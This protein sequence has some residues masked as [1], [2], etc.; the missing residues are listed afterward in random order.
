MAPKP[1]NEHLPIAIIGAGI[2]GLTLAQ[3]CRRHN[4][5][6]RLLERHPH[7]H[8]RQGHRFRVSE[9][10]FAALR[11][12]ALADD[13]ELRDLLV[14]TAPCRRKEGVAQR[15][16]R[17][18]DAKTF[19]MDERLLARTT[20]HVHSVPIDRG[21]V[22]AVLEEGLGDAVEYGREFLR[23]EEKEDEGED[24]R[25]FVRVWFT[26]GSFLDASLLV[27]A[28]GVRSLVRRQLQPARRLLDLNR[29]I[30][31]GRTP[32]VAGAHK[33]GGDNDT[34]MSS[35][36][37]AVDKEAGAQCVVEAITWD[38]EARQAAADAGLSPS[39]LGDYSYW[40]IATAPASGEHGLPQTAEETRAFVARITEGWHPRLKKVLDGADYGV[41]TCIP[42]VSSK[43]DIELPVEGNGERR[44]GRVLVTII[45]DAAHAMSPMGQAGGDLAIRDAV[46]L[47][48]AI[49]R[50]RDEEE[51]EEQGRSLMA[52]ERVM[53]ARAKENLERAFSNGR[54]FWAKEGYREV[55]L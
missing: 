53:A 45:G 20:A 54:R 18:P 44:R 33:S 5:P 13:R 1:P 36:L 46:D 17:F 49:A 16:P 47:A 34:D 38:D 27:G 15:P 35:W 40:A 41:A 10:A 11:D 2:A 24:G 23:Y 26:D 55:H 21:W 51:G 4:I 7:G 12:D 30:V 42:V 52:F 48:R 37:M 31:W 22:R 8:R 3:A 14:R 25:C 19:E 29:W 9:E 43:P 28:D 39:L 32:L 50:G 6:F